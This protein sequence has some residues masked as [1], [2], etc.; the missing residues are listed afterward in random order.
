MSTATLSPPSNRSSERLDLTGVDFDEFRRHPL[1]EDTLRCL[2]YMHDVERH[3]VCYLRDVLVTSAHREPDLTT[4]MTFWVYQEHWHGEAIGQVI[5][6][7]VS[8][9]AASPGRRGC[10]SRST[11]IRPV[12]GWPRAPSPAGSPASPSAISGRRSVPA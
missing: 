1:D 7:W 2:R 8:S 6:C 9:S 4:F 10:T 5:R 12:A 3:T 11:P